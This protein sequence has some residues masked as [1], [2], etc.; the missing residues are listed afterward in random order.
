MKTPSVPLD[1]HPGPSRSRLHK[2]RLLQLALRRMRSW[3]HARWRSRLLSR[4]DLDHAHR[5]RLDLDLFNVATQLPRRHEGIHN[6]VRDGGCY[7]TDPMN[8]VVIPEPAANVDAEATG[9]VHGR[10]S[11]ARNREAQGENEGADCQTD[12]EWRKDRPEKLLVA[13]VDAYAER[14]YDGGQTSDKFN[15]HGSTHC[16]FFSLKQE[17]ATD[18]EVSS[19]PAGPEKQA[20]QSS[21][22]QLEED[23][24]DSAG[25]RGETDAEG[26][27]RKEGIQMATC[28]GPE[29]EDRDP[30]EEHIDRAAD[31]RT[32]EV[33]CAERSGCGRECR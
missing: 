29:S 10:S 33:D 27:D 19:A 25:Q 11:I 26:S 1:S 17:T 16:C 31:Q 13:R 22:H 21:A 14:K 6:G 18:F 15:C 24:E 3:Q 7:G 4:L 5:T 28:D 8:P 20:C 30:E 9:R 12:E 32:Q 23:V 2:L